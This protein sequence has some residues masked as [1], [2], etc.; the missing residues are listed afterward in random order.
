MPTPNFAGMIK[1]RLDTTYLNLDALSLDITITNPLFDQDSSEALFTF[2]FRLPATPTNLYALQNA[3]RLDNA[4]NTTTYLGAV[5]EIEG[6][7]FEPSG[8]LELDEQSFTADAINVVFK[9]Q[10]PKLFEQFDKL[11]INDLL[12][13]ITIPVVT[14]PLWKFAL[15]VPPSSAGITYTIIIDTI[16]YSYTTPSSVVNSA[17]TRSLA[18]AINAAHPGLADEGFNNELW[19]NSAEVNNVAIDVPNLVNL[20]DPIVV[21]VG[22]AAMANLEAFVDDVSWTPDDR[23]SFPYLYWKRFYKGN[24]E[25]YNDRHNTWVDGDYIHNTPSTTSDRTWSAGFIPLVRIPYILDRIAAAVPDYFTQHLGF[26]AEADGA[27]LL[28]LNN[29]AL[30]QVY[31]DRYANIGTGVFKY[32]NGHKTSIYLNEHVPSL[33]ASQFIRYL[34]EQFQ[35]YMVVVGTTI[36]FR[37]KRDMLASAPLDWT[38]LS[39]PSYTATRKHRRG[40][41]LQYP[42]LRSEDKNFLLSAASNYTSQLLD[43]ASG[44]G[45]EEYTL[46][47]GTAMVNDTVISLPISGGVLKCPDLS[48]F[49]S[50]DEADLGD[51]PISLRL[52]FDRGINITDQG[53]NYVMATHDTTDVDGN[54]A[55]DLSLDLNAPDGLYHLHHKGITELLADGQPVTLPMRLGIADIL[56]L[57]KWTNARRTIV[58]PEGQVTAVVKS[59]KFKAG[60]DGIGISLVEFV[61]EK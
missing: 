27:Q 19:L 31:Y 55:G 6:L 38:H 36:E 39:E 61:Q 10:V 60:S 54:P 50:S 41:T 4:D 24:V 52:L 58:L 43:Y 23:V 15:S 33:G 18:L 37:K 32:L 47:F 48:Q 8:I 12:E 51:N 16:A 42:E 26:F 5:F 44:E 13:T 28:L 30:D 20:D 1:L 46:P 7:P 59:V 34:L 40:F 53:D 14:Q 56:E 11:K 25:G 49:G 35:L 45:F 57:R 9:N 29:R 3:N 21:T 2:P 22:E 17:V